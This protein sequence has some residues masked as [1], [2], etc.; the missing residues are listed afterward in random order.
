MI[1]HAGSFLWM[2]T[3]NTTII[4]I[5]FRQS[6]QVLLRFRV[7]GLKSACMFAFVREFSKPIQKDDMPLCRV[8]KWLVNL[9]RNRNFKFNL[10][11]DVTIAWS[12][13]R[14]GEDELP[15]CSC[16]TIVEWKFERKFTVVSAQRGSHDIGCRNWAWG[17]LT[18]TSV[19]STI[20]LKMGTHHLFF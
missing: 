4:Q 14:A 7:S 9:L 11:T 17:I 5:Y 3:Y 16:C 18:W 15:C 1:W 20:T 19:E 10:S 6:Q 8:K 2:L 13:D 12:F